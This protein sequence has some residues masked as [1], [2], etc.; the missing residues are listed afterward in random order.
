MIVNKIIHLSFYQCYPRGRGVGRG[1]DFDI[2]AKIFVNNNPPHHSPGNEIGGEGTPLVTQ[3]WGGRHKTFF[4][5]N[6][7]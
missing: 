1:G 6:S 2:L 4:L 7:L 3:Y 5:T